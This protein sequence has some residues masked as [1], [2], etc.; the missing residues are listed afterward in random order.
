MHLLRL[1]MRTIRNENKMLTI[2]SYLY[3][4]RKS[5][6]RNVFSDPVYESI[7]ERAEEQILTQIL[8]DAEY[9]KDSQ[10]PVNNV[11]AI[12]NA[13]NELRRWL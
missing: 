13:S 5:R 2:Y 10:I 12:H 4:T 9:V 1:R 3:C 7:L 6:D 11:D 8:V